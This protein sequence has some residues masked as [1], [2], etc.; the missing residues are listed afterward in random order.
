VATTRS[1][2]PRTDKGWELEGVRPDHEVLADRAL[3][4]ALE[5]AR[6]R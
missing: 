2:D 4:T 1:V 6:K 3:E 5:L